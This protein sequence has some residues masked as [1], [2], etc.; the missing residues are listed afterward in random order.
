VVASEVRAL[1]GRS[2][3]AAK[4]IK[5]LINASVERVEHMA[6]AASSLKSQAG[7][8]VQTVAVLKLN[9]SAGVGKVAV[10]STE[11]STL[12]FRG[13]E[14][15]AMVTAKVTKSP[16]RA[17]TKA[18]TTASTPVLAVPKYVA[19]AATSDDWESF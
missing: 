12:P 4:E 8:L 1:A 11:S 5:N 18:R 14:R 17:D 2:A 9:G 19:T 16:G 7:T 10:R 3:E 6:A 13:A 15:R